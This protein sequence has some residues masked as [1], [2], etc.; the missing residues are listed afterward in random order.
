MNRSASASMD[1]VEF[2]FRFTPIVPLPSRLCSS[3]VLSIRNAFP[4]QLDDAWSHWERHWSER[5]WRGSYDQT[6]LRYSGL[7]R[8]QDPSFSQSRPFLDCFSGTFSP[9]RCHRGS[10]RLS[11]THRREGA[12]SIP[13]QRCDPTVAVPSILTGQFTHLRNQ[14]VFI[15]PPLR[16]PPLCGS[17]WAPYV[18]NAALRNTHLAAYVANAGT[19]TGRAQGLRP[20]SLEC[21]PGSIISQTAITPVAASDRISL[22]RGRSDTARHSRSFSC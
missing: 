20:F 8:T 16:H 7:S 4:S 9:S 17:I 10:S 22:S 2:S 19:A 12:A 15:A 6:W 13:Q 18:T 14:A 5:Q 11:F 1:S 21:S 3:R